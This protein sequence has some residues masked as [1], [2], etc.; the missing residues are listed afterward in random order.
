MLRA[1]L[2]VGE[3]HGGRHLLVV[4]GALACGGHGGRPAVLGRLAAHL[5]G[6][7]GLALDLGKVLLHLLR[8]QAADL[9]APELKIS[10]KVIYLKLLTLYLSLSIA[11][12]TKPSRMKLN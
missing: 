3:A 5:V 1:H 9:F 12:P 10:E 7:L 8:A 4:L 6:Q 11:Y 2:L